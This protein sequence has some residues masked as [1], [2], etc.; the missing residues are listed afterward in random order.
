MIDVNG[1]IISLVLFRGDFFWIIINIIDNF[2]GVI[3]YCNIEGI[4]RMVIVL[5]NIIV[6]FLDIVVDERYNI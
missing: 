5:Y 6:E 4:S 3:V 2:I 1:K